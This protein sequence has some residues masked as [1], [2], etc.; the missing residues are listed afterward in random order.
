MGSHHQT[1]NTVSN[2]VQNTNT[3]SLRTH[4]ETHNR[5]YNIKKDT[6]NNHWGDTIEGGMRNLHGSTNTGSQCFGPSCHLMNLEAAQIDLQN[7][8]PIE[9]EILNDLANLRATNPA[10]Y[11][12]K[13]EYLI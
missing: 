12:R 2:N 3:D 1:S 13:L 4:T 8:A 9:R 11:V 10:A 6:T 5:N 7:L